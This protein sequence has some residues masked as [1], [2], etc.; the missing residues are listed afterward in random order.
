M[1]IVAHPQTLRVKD[2]VFGCVR[3]EERG[4]VCVGEPL[5]RQAE[6][7]I[8]VENFDALCVSR[9]VETLPAGC[10]VFC[11]APA[12]GAGRVT[13]SRIEVYF[14]L[15]SAIWRSRARI[16]FFAW[17]VL[18][19]VSSF[20]YLFAHDLGHGVATAAAETVAATTR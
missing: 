6:G 13:L 2:A 11:R 8:V 17:I 12:N 16:M 20:V 1:S 14:P 19:V 7:R 9:L 18:P 15:E 3:E 10:R 5:R 4:R